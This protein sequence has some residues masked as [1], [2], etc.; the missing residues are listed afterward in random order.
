MTLLIYLDC[1]GHELGGSIRMDHG[2]ELACLFTLIDMLLRKHKYVIEPTG[3]DS[4]SQNE[5][6]EIYNAKLAV[7]T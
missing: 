3:V 6:V 5:A 2:G 7:C 4:P 1:C